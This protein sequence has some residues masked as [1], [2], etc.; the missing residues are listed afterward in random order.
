[1]IP[2]SLEAPRAAGSCHNVEIAHLVAVD[3]TT[4][5]VTAGNKDHVV[6]L[7]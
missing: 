4:G 6:V 2:I 7:N 3:R 1:M 5:V